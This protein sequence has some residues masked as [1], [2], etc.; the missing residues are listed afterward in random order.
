MQVCSADQDCHVQMFWPSI[1]SLEY[2]SVA[3]N[4]LFDNDRA[5]QLPDIEPLWPTR[6]HL[7]RSEDQ[8]TAA[9]LEAKN[10]PK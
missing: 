7:Q 3:Y 8:Q 5:V 9:L 6:Y 10:F 2:L 1:Y 4:L